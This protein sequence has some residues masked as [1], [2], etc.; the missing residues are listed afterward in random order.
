MKNFKSWFK[1]NEGMSV[2][3][4]GYSPEEDI[5]DLDSICNIIRNKLVYPLFEKLPKENKD[6]IQKLGGLNHGTI[7]PD[8]SFYD[9][10]EQTINLYLEGWPAEFAQKLISGTKYYLDSLKIKYGSFKKEKSGLYGGE[11]I[12]I[13]VLS[14]VK[15]KNVPPSLDLNNANAKLIF[16]DILGIKG[17]E[18]GFVISPQE[19][20]FKIDSYDRMNL[21]VHARDSFMSKTKNGP[22]VFH[23][24]LNKQDIML[25]LDT[26]K[27]IAKWA[28]E[29]HYDKISVS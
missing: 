19:L 14:F 16:S 28:I 29:N 11:V 10:Q 24:G 22:Q 4:V 3:I 26:I 20:I 21:D 9:K 5:K 13:P 23:G 12:R 15:T 18:E 17:S 27:S 7:V 1:I 8:G 6:L 2:N 25:R